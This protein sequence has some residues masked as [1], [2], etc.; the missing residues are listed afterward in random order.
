MIFVSSEFWAEKSI[1]HKFD[2]TESIFRG[3][4]SEFWELKEYNWIQVNTSEYMWIQ[5]KQLNT[6]EYKWIHDFTQ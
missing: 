6:C 4:K 3:M 5:V 1:L 2:E